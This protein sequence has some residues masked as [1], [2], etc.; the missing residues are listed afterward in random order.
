MTVGYEKIAEDMGFSHAAIMRTSDLVIVPEYRKYCEENLC[1]RYGKEPNCPPDVGTVAEL[2]AKI[3]GYKTAIVLQ[4]EVDAAGKD[5]NDFYESQKAGVNS[6]TEEM[7]HIVEKY[8]K[9]QP[10]M[11][12]AGP[13]KS[14]A[15]VSAYCIDCQKMADHLGMKCWENDD[16]LR[17]FS[18]ILY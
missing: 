16:K 5:M 11:I 4:M 18:I 2:K 1:G 8:E 3:Y 10:L 7:V 14:S 12:S 13:W 6:L 9:K 15:C 17:L